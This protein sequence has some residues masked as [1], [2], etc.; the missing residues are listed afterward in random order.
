MMI[1][2]WKRGRIGRRAALRAIAGPL[3]TLACAAF[4]E[5]L[6]GSPLHFPGPSV[7]LLVAVAC[8]AYAG[9]F[10]PGSA[11]CAAIRA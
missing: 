4:T 5:V 1:A 3:L 10:V 8:G 9:G 7:I 6:R 11:K 2:G